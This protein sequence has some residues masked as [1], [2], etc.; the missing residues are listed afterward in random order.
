[1]SHACQKPLLATRVRPI[2][3]WGLSFQG[4][5]RAPNIRWWA[6][7]RKGGQ[8]KP[9]SNFTYLNGSYCPHPRRWFSNLHSNRLD[10]GTSY[11]QP[12]QTPRSTPC[13]HLC[14]SGHF[15]AFG[16]SCWC[17]CWDTV[18]CQSVPF[19]TSQ[20]RRPPSRSDCFNSHFPS[21]SKTE[22]WLLQF[23]QV[24]DIMFCYFPSTESLM[25]CLLATRYMML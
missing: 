25:L 7:I 6:S 19:M 17:V 14:P 23:V 4:C 13:W 11:L 5:D 2:A 10:S 20:R 18:V 1:M 21:G 3:L 9:W 16:R 12:P 8:E 24:I 15:H 22:T